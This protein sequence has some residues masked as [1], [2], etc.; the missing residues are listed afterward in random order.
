MIY[1]IKERLY[2]FYDRLDRQERE[3]AAEGKAAIAERIR[4]ERLTVRAVI[5]IIDEEIIEATNDIITQEKKHQGAPGM[6]AYQIRRAED[7]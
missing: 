5:R 6:L 3:A 7:A 2:D 1:R 4:D